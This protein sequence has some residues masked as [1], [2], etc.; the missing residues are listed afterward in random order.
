MRV[1]GHAV[2]HEIGKL[3]TVRC[4]QV[5]LSC[6]KPLLL[7]RVRHKIQSHWKTGKGLH[8]EKLFNSLCLLLSTYVPVG[9]CV[10]TSVSFLS[11]RGI[12]PL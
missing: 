10:F 9:V 4:G 11:F 2:G 5:T 1:I 8:I 6:I 3:L 12:S 7:L